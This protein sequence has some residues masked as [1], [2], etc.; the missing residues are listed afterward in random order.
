MVAFGSERTGFRRENQEK[1]GGSRMRA[2]AQMGRGGGGDPASLPFADGAGRAAEQF[3]PAEQPAAGGEAVPDGGGC[4]RAGDRE[5]SRAGDGPVR[6]AAGA[7][8]VGTGAGG[9]TDSRSAERERTG[10]QRERRRGGERQHG[11]R[12]VERRGG[13]GG[14][15]GGGG[16]RGQWVD[17]AGGCDHAEPRPGSAKYHDAGAPDATAGQHGAEPDECAGAT[18]ARHE[19]DLAGGEI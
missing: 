5:Q 15:R 7:I 3:G 14:A 9:G 10:F 13:R 18:G 12:G 19:Y 16:G 11:E 1:I 4:D 8:G 6:T 17:S 2:L